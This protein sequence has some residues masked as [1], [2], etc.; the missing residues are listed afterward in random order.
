M[1]SSCAFFAS[2]IRPPADKPPAS[3][4]QAAFAKVLGFTAGH[5]AETRRVASVARSGSSARW[6]HHRLIAALAWR[7][8]RSAVTNRNNFPDS[9]S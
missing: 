5:P 7:S 4:M 3:G 6:G 8:R 1:M 9:L 2:L